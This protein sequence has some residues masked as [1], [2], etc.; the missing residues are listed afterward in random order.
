MT[1]IV[2]VIR[3]EFCGISCHSSMRW[4]PTYAHPILAV[5]QIFP[6]YKSQMLCL[7][8]TSKTFHR[9]SSDVQ[10]QSPKSLWSIFQSPVG[11]GMFIPFFCEKNKKQKK[12]QSTH[13]TKKYPW[14]LLRLKLDILHTVNFRLVIGIVRGYK[15]LQRYSYVRS[16]KKHY[17][18]NKSRGMFFLTQIMNCIQTYRRERHHCINL[19]AQ[20]VIIFTNQTANKYGTTRS[21]MSR[22][23]NEGV[24]M[25]CK[26]IT[27]NLLKVV[28]L[29]VEPST[30]IA[31]PKGYLE[32]YISI[33]QPPRTV[34]SRN[35]VKYTSL[36]SFLF[37]SSI[38]I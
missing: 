30:D 20:S 10:T 22:V 18:L 5:T 4:L 38:M 17:R 33:R 6:L 36:L 14:G 21:N 37:F 35:L 19:L 8:C 34:N 13:F 2:P 3:C 7:P 26:A 24:V 29:I 23:T 12:F 28:G 25:C 9:A 32:A 15:Y 1:H 31:K 27:V 16:S 11:P